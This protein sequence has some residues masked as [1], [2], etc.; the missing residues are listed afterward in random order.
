M[1][2][3]YPELS[4]RIQSTFI[5]TVLIIV[6]IFAFARILDNYENVPDG[7]RI[8]MF[9]GLF[10]AYEPIC[11]TL[12]STLGNY[13]KGIRVRQNSNSTRR[14]TI[15]QAIIRYPVKVLLGWVSFLTIGATSKR[16]AIH[17]LVSGSVMIKL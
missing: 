2:E 4:E 15:F 3:K 14:I 10:M 9:V 11:M 16:R 12:G 7:V 1:Q 17:D 6:L 5:D 13:L 8:V